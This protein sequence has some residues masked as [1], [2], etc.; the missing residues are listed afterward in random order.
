MR[1]NAIETTKNFDRQYKKLPKNVK[2]AA[3]EKEWIFRENPFDIRLRTHKLHGEEKDMW[4]FS[5]THT[6]RIKFIFITDESVLF[7]EIGTHG[8]YR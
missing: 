2:D 7:L 8:I 1:V 3:K 4:A 6:H 5:I